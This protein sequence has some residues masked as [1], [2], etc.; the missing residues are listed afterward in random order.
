V[1]LRITRE[2]GSRYRANLKLEGRLVAEWTALLE[3]E[4]LDLLLSRGAVRLDLA[5]VVFVDRAGVEVLRRLSHMGVEIHCQ[6]RLIA[7]VLEGEGVH[8]TVDADSAN[9]GRA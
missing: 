9:D 6:S 3:R 2:R 8:V 4:C 7:S 5:G 1:T